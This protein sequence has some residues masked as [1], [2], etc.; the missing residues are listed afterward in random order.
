L[1]EKCIRVLD[2][3][4]LAIKKKRKIE[5]EVIDVERSSS[6]ESCFVEKE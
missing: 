5:Y 2:E 6:N 3:V 4:L 1:E